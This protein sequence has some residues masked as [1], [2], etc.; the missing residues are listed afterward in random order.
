MSVVWRVLYPKQWTA[1]PVGLLTHGSVTM[2]DEMVT[3]RSLRTLG[4]TAGVALGLSV[5]GLGVLFVRMGVTEADKWASSLGVFVGLFA[6]TLSAYSGV[7]THRSSTQ[8]RIKPMGRGEVRN[9]IRGGEFAQSVNQLRDFQEG[10]V[11]GPAEAGAE[12]EATGAT[13]DGR[14]EN[15]IDSGTFHGPVVQGRDV[16]R[17]WLSPWG[18]SPKPRAEFGGNEP[19]QGGTA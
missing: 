8:G 13:A 7:L 6:L 5:V 17:L 2:D 11:A 4:W 15:V 12:P 16:T 18:G 9:T 1:S 3:K 10:M 19:S 14:V